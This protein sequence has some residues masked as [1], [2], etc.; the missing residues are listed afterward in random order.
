MAWTRFASSRRSRR[1]RACAHARTSSRSRRKAAVACSSNSTAR[2]RSKARKNPPSSPSSC[3]CSS[4]N[5]RRRAN[6]KLHIEEHPMANDAPIAPESDIREHAAQHTLAANP[7]VGVRGE[8]ILDSAQLLLAQML[9]NP[10]AAAQQYLTFLGELG[11]IAAGASELKPDA[12]DRRFADPAWRE[13]L[14]YRSLAQGYLAWSNALY[15]F[16]EQAK[17][18]KRDAERA[19]FVVSLIVDAMAPTNAL[20]SNPAALKKLVD[21]GGAS[22]LHGLENFVGDDRK[23]VV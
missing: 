22:F 8:D 4:A 9:S 7:L 17:I 12:N 3:A 21:S 10:V 18:N 5:T 11:R 13:S 15:G 6:G 1:A 2:W 23:S 19:R 20:V 16:L 14:A